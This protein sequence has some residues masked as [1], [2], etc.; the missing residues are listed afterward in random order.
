VVGSGIT[1]QQLSPNDVGLP[2]TENAAA[3]ALGLFAIN[4]DA[5]AGERNAFQPV[6]SFVDAALGGV[7]RRTQ[8]YQQGAGVNIAI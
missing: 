4:L 8:R 6:V 5:R 3:K 1:A 2:L 7:P